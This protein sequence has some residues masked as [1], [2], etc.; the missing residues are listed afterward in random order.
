MLYELARHICLS[1]KVHVLVPEY[2]GYGCYKHTC[3]KRKLLRTTT[4]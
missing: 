2:P 1:L 4:E 3:V